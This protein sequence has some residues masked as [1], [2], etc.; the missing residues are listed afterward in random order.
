MRDSYFPEAGIWLKGNL[1]SHSTVSDGFFTPEQLATMYAEK[2]YDFLSMTDH[3]V[4]V[5]HDELPEEQILLMTGV[6]HDIAYSDT[7][8][9]HVVGIGQPEKEATDYACRCYHKEELADQQLLDMMYQDGQFVTLAHPIWSRMEPE[10]VL[11]LHNFHAIEVFN[12]GTEH[13]GHGG[14]AEIYWD[15]LL[16]RGYKVLGTCSDDVH[17][18]VDLFGGWLWVKAAD[19][20]KKAIMDALFRGDYYSSTGP[21]IED[22]GIDNGKVYV[23]CSPCREIHFVAYDPRGLSL[24]AEDTLLTEG[25]CPLSGRE[26]YVR[27]VCVDEN[28]HSAWTNP[29]FF[30]KRA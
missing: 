30:D 10:E 12:N 25:V 15:M 3:N 23:K 22:F 26:A 27:A 20:S 11:A 13:L 16:R 17:G 1:H 4:Y 28:G 6:E 18:G 8:C 9:I 5:A 24:F 14:N 7:K 2:G 29:I 21:V 19:R